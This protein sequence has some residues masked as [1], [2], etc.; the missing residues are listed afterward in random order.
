MKEWFVKVGERLKLYYLFNEYY[1]KFVLFFYD[2]DKFV[3][4][5]KID[6]LKNM[7]V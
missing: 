1:L 4:I 7:F 5:I 3:F 2:R 6:Y